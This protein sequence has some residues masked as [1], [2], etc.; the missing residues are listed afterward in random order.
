[1]R[2]PAESR[3]RLLGAAEQL[4][5]DR[6]YAAASVRGITTAAGCNVAAVN[7]YFGGKDRLYREVFRRG[8]SA[9]RARR[10]ASIRRAMEDAGDGATLEGLLEA[11]TSAFLEPA[12][13]PAGG[14]RF[15]E[16]IAREWMDP[17]LPRDV[18]RK[19][20]VGP[21]REALTDAILA[22][23]PGLD[24]SKANLCVQS[25]VAQLVQVIQH[26]RLFGTLGEWSRNSLRLEEVAEHI[27]R[28]SAAGTRASAGDRRG[29]PASSGRTGARSR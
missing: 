9:L 23:C 1:V 26:R 28:F 7:Y 25:I 13:A 17:H 5:A 29:A 22:T 27:V 12:V 6:G 2:P 14:G 4:F 10:I 20:L 15:A 21:V 8:L 11:F 16:L 24:R 3:D 18:F 19:E